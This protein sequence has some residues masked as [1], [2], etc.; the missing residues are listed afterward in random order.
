MRAGDLANYRTPA[1]Q[2]VEVGT[3]YTFKRI[4]HHAWLPAPRSDI[5]NG[6]QIGVSRLLHKKER[7]LLAGDNLESLL[8]GR[9]K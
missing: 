4:Q 3:I 8:G 9:K 5:G 2:A 7:R 1:A 6:D